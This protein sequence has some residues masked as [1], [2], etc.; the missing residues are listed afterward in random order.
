MEKINV[1]MVCKLMPYYR[2]GVFQSLSTI[3]ETYEFSFFGDTKEQGG[4]KQIP[5]SYATAGGEGRI[6]WIKTGNYF[7]KPER[8]LWQ[9]GIIKEIFRS[10]FKVFV[11]EGALAHLPISVICT[12]L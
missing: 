11:F 4:I 3:T 9:T 7:Y 12:A 5:F 6:R 2:L 8:L 1:A 10:K